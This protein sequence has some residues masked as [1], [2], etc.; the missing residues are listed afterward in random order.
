MAHKRFSPR[1]EYYLNATRFESYML[2]GGVFLFGFT[3]F[4]IL[5]VLVGAAWIVWP[6]MFLSIAAAYYVLRILKKREYQQKLLELEA[7]YRAKEQ[8]L[9]E[10]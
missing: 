7:D 4:F 6:G 2:I 10:G 5:G 3:L 8:L 9:G 1:D